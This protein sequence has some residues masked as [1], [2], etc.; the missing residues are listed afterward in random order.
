MSNIL[1]LCLPDGQLGTGLNS[2]TGPAEKYQR[3]PLTP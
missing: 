1:A 3:S 2:V